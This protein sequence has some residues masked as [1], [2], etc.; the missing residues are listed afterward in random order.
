MVQAKCLEVV[1]VNNKYIGYNL[2]D[3]EG[4]SV[5]MKTVELKKAILNG[6]LDVIN[7]TIDSNGKIVEKEV[8]EGIN[9]LVADGPKLVNG[10]KYKNNIKELCKYFEIEYIDADVSYDDDTEMYGYSFENDKVRVWFNV[11]IEST[12]IGLELDGIDMQCEFDNKSK[13][14]LDG[15][16]VNYYDFIKVVKS[17]I[18]D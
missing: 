8:T 14:R 6:S 3:L 16:A 18:N 9:H 1:K 11:G 17:A 13:S 12:K 2:I 4:N 10:K 15:T 5:T 7:L